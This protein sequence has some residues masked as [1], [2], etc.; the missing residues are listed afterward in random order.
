MVLDLASPS[1]LHA[2]VVGDPI[3]FRGA[4]PHANRYPPPLG[5]DNRAVLAR[6][7][8]LGEAELDALHR[9]KVLWSKRRVTPREAS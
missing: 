3:K 4:P 8:G 2:R 1:G 9:D 7:L 6:I 5:A